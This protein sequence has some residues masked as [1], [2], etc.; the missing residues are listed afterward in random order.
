M[1]AYVRSVRVSLHRQYFLASQYT[2]PARM[3]V[4]VAALASRLYYTAKAP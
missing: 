4:L 3:V 2:A 1:P